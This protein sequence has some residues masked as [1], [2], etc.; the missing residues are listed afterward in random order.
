MDNLNTDNNLG[1]SKEFITLLLNAAETFDSCNRN[2]QKCIDSIIVSSYKQCTKGSHHKNL[3]LAKAERLKNLSKLNTTTAKKF[4]EMVRKLMNGEP[5]TVVLSH[6]QNFG[7]FVNDQIRS[8][9]SDLENIL[10]ILHNKNQ[11]S[12]DS[13]L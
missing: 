4:R 12:S 7:T 10:N 8:H 3:L 2:I 1:N 5:E 11:S 13:L 6:L 9:N